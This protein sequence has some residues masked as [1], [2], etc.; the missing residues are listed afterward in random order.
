MR[1]PYDI[2]NNPRV[3]L[4]S[5]RVEGGAFT[6]KRDAGS[7]LRVI[8]S[9]DHGWDHVSVSLSN[10]CPNYDEMKMVKRIF[11]EDHEWAMELHAPI[12]KHI[13]IHPYCL[14][15]WRPHSGDIPTPP[16]YLV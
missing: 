13:N 5:V 7:P 15:L 9:W 2:M 8:A 14:H 16:E 12:S 4:L 11:F 1:S 10:R 6:V 3:N